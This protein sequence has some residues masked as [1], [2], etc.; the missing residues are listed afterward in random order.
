M[1]PA[2]GL[3]SGP[4]ANWDV[5]LAEYLLAFGYCISQD[6]SLS[7][8]LLKYCA[9]KTAAISAY[10]QGMPKHAQFFSAGNNTS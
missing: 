1:S 7:R 10:L 4:A 3:E 2:L 8:V 5:G 9:L 6:E